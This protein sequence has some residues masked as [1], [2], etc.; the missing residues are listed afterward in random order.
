MI[1]T[2]D[3]ASAEKCR[4]LR[5][6]CFQAKK[7]FIHEEIGWNFRFTNLQAALGLAQLETLEAH[8]RRK[9]AMGAKYAELL[10][11]IPGIQLPC[12]ITNYADNIYW[13]FGIVL[14]D[15]YPF[16]ADEVARRLAARKIGTRPFFWPMHEQPVFQKKG[17]FNGVCCPVAE[18]IARRGFYV[19][20]G[21]ALTEQEMELVAA[22]LKEVLQ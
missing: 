2:D 10:K 13:V 18:R 19:P 5:N 6:L 21:L 22:D 7:R 14:G 15:S 20:S 12:P 17:L 16:D 4:S 9:R 11:D 8:I 1:V 3:P